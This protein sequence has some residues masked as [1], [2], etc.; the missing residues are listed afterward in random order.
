MMRGRTIRTCAAL[1][2]G[3]V[4]ACCSNKAKYED[5]P[6]PGEFEFSLGWE[7]DPGLGPSTSSGTVTDVRENPAG[8]LEITVELTAGEHEPGVYTFRVP[9]LAGVEI[10]LQPGDEV[11]VGTNDL[12]ICYGCSILELIIE[13]DGE[14][15]LYALDCENDLCNESSF[16]VGLLHF[17]IVSGT[18]APWVEYAY[19]PSHDEWCFLKEDSGLEVS[20]L[21]GSGTE[22]IEQLFV[23]EQASLDCGH[24]YHVAAGTQTRV[25]DVP[26]DFYCMD[27]PKDARQLLVIRGA[28]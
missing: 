11:S 18:C 13:R 14:P 16:D 6:E 21:D 22:Q 7:P 23:G 3:A 1:C 9:L 12:T 24:V 5:C 20:C 10:D 15:I 17:E 19:P 2:M 4:V 27:W 28:E 26:E 25:L 8:T